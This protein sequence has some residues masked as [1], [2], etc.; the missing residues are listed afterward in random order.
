[1]K[2]LLYD[3]VISGAGPSGAAAARGLSNAGLK[4]LV[5][6]KNRLP[7]YK[8]CSGIIFKKSQDLTEKYFGKI[9]DTAYV[10]PHL[11]SGVRL[12]SDLERF[13]DWPFNK[14]GNGAPNIWR[15]K[16]LLLRERI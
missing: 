15:S 13:T 1:M 5:I 3:V 9:P 16:Y 6:E 14:N 2:H 7:R 10:K 11:L 12:W 8:M 4:V